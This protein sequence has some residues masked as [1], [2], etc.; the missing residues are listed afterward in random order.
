MASKNTSPL[1]VRRLLDRVAG[2]PNPGAPAL[3]VARPGV[4]K[5]ALLVHVALEALIW[6]RGVLHVALSDDV[7]GVRAHYDTVLRARRDAGRSDGTLELGVERRRM[8]LSYA[9]RDFDVEHLTAQVQMLSEVAGFSPDLII[10]DG[11]DEDTWAEHGAPLAA[12]S[13]ALGAPTWVS[14]VTAEGQVPQAPVDAVGFVVR[15]IPGTAD[16]GAGMRLHLVQAGVESELPWSLDAGTSLLRAAADGPIDTTKPLPA[17]G[18][19]TLFSGGA[20]GSEAAFGEVAA[21]HGVREVHFTFEGHRQARTQGARTLSARELEAGDVSLVYVS[22]RL[23]RTYSERGLIRKVLQLLW[24][25]VSRSQQVFVVGAI[26]D[27]G[28]VVGGTGWSVELAR[29]WKKDLWVFDQDRDGWFTWD[30]EAWVPGH[31]E[32]RAAQ[33]CGTGTRYLE[34]NGRAAIEA[35]FA[36]AFGGSSSTGVGNG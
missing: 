3:V 6:D 12:L 31:A 2:G 9:E 15:M 11:L 17:A 33:F 1:P 27:D 7:S 19:C 18:E 21:A 32:I 14:V 28:T 36:E 8:V 29:M 23:N 5:T 16:E 34:D 20:T 13:E 25:V 24:H 26:Q 10:V 22:R 30:G 35:L 4:G